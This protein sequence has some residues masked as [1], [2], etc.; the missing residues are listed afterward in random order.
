MGETTEM[1][2]SD[3]LENM[4]GVDEKTLIELSDEGYFEDGAAPVPNYATGFSSNTGP[5]GVLADRRQHIAQKNEEIRA[6]IAAQQQTQ[7]QFVTPNQAIDPLEE[8][9]DEDKK[10][11]ERIRQNRLDSMKR[12]ANRPSFG[13]LLSIGQ[14][15]FV[16][17][18]EDE[19]DDVIVVLH[20][21]ENHIAACRQ[22]NECLSAIASEMTHVKFLKLLAHEAKADF[23][24]VA[25]PALVLYRGG[26]TLNA[27]MR[28]SDDLPNPFEEADVAEF[29]NSKGV[30]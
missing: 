27:C 16:S 24:E 3:S 14:A 17:S 12:N 29:L 25:L 6:S 8:E 2:E 23:D 11:L 13:K 20:L 30:C 26:D 21:Y 18:V 9:D 28:I 7:M 22:V 1:A 5:K 19:R 15:Q 4:I 10:E